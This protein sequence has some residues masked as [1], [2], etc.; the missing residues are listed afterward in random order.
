VVQS[1]PEPLTF[2]RLGPA[3]FNRRDAHIS[4]WVESEAWPEE[5]AVAKPGDRMSPVP[6][7]ARPTSI[8][9]NDHDGIEL[10]P[11]T[12]VILREIKGAPYAGMDYPDVLEE[13]NIT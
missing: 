13:Q 5:M 8:P 11:S 2:A 9:A 6:F 7:M 10:V 12:F 1:L 4:Y 3:E